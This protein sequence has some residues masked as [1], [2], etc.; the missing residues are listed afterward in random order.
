M[1][2]LVERSGTTGTEPPHHTSP[3]RGVGNPAPLPGRASLADRNP[4][5]GA[6]G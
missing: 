4:V 6:T 5:A 2:R 3:G 1:S